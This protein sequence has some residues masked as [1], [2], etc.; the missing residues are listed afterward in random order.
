VSEEKIFRTII[1]ALRHDPWKYGLEL[2]TEG[3]V[4]FEDLVIGLR[5]DRYAWALLESSEVERVVRTFGEGRFEI[6]DG[7]VRATYG[8]SIELGRLPPIEEPPMVLFHGST[9]EVLA[10]ILQ[11]GL[12]P[13]GRRFVHLT[14]D[15]GYA[16]RVA[17]AKGGQAVLVINAAQASAAGASFRRANEH[18]WL[19]EIGIPP[20]FLD[21]SP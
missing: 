5:F 19:A 2:D 9:E 20:A 11:Q 21:A 10:L 1:H 18:V 13:I 17:A 3:C 14:S 6:S 8:H 12:K 16:L 7:R 4:A 15:R